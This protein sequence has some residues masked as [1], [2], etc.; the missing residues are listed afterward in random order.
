MLLLILAWTAIVRY[1]RQPSHAL[2]SVLVGVL[3]GI[4]ILM[5]QFNGVLLTAGVIGLLPFAK[6]RVGPSLTQTPSLGVSGAVVTVVIGYALLGA[7]ALG[8]W[9]PAAILGW[10]IGYG[11]SHP[12]GHALTVAGVKGAVYALGESLLAYVDETGPFRLLGVSVLG[13]CA[14]L[15]LVGLSAVRLLPEHLWAMVLACGLQCVVGWLLIIWWS[16]IPNGPNVGKWRMLTWPA[17][18]SGCACAL[19]GFLHQSQA[20]LCGRRL[21]WHRLWAVMPLLLGACLLVLNASALLRLRAPDGPFE[22][23][24][25][26]WVTHSG[27]DDVL[28]LNW[29]LNAALL[30]W[31]KRAGVVDFYETLLENQDPA[32]RFASVRAVMEQA[33]QRHRR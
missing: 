8:S 21:P 17:L 16:P 1:V 10:A 30:Y 6:R 13:T 11:S 12:Y 7:L 32:D 4:A 25:S 33:L 18:L 19:E 28:L 24:V 9:S 2:H 14:L 20:S 29:E 26:A 22:Q 3:T 23:A 27:P 31:E 5:N 15:L